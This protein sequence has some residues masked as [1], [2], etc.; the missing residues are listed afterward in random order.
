MQRAGYV[1]G[2]CLGRGGIGLLDEQ[3]LFAGKR[4]E[5]FKPSRPGTMVYIS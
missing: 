1:A 3:L 4:K 2:G 5:V